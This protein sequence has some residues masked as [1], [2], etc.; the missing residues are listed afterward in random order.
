[1]GRRFDKSREYLVNNG[2][3]GNQ[4]GGARK[5][6]RAGGRAGGGRIFHFIAEGVTGYV[7]EARGERLVVARL[8]ESNHDEGTFDCFE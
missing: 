2:R 6:P 8:L 7:Q 3:G 5:R 4:G 1:M